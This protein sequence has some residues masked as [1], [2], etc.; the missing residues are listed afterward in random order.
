M[1]D[2]RRLPETSSLLLLLLSGT[3]RATLELLLLQL[4]DPLAGQGVGR[5]TPATLRSAH[6][7]SHWS[8]LSKHCA[9]IG[10]D[11]DLCLYGIRLAF[12]V[13]LKQRIIGHWPLLGFWTG[14]QLRPTRHE[15]FNIHT[16]PV[17]FFLSK[18]ILRI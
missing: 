2:R 14:N 16:F 13:L 17:L 11:H 5:G 9:L 3:S 18:R 10:W 6:L 1:V 15:K 4:H 8:D 7:H 12:I